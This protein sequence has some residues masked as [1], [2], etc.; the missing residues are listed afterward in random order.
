MN[1]NLAS[2][3][4][5]NLTSSINSKLG[6]IWFSVVRFHLVHSSVQVPT[7]WWSKSSFSLIGTKGLCIGCIDS[8][9]L[10]G[11]YQ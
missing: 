8:E 5:S 10:M 3:K 7:W 4:I 1:Q 6:E 9:A 11:Q 2:H